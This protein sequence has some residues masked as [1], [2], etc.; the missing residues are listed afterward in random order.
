VAAAALELTN[1]LGA[2]QP[3]L[4][5]QYLVLFSLLSIL[6]FRH[7][8]TVRLWFALLVSVR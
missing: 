6:L 8:L 2:Q 3:A 1:L 5:A 4:A 7:L